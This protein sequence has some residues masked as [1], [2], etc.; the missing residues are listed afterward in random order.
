MLYG[1]IEI[2]FNDDMESGCFRQ[3]VFKNVDFRKFNG[4]LTIHKSEVENLYPQRNEIAPI[5][6][7]EEERIVSLKIVRSLAVE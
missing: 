5:F 2:T 7:I 4:L 1:E 6:G 3:V